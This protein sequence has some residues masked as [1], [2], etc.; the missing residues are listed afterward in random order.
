MSQ[1]SNIIKDRVSYSH[2]FIGIFQSGIG[3]DVDEIV[4]E[5]EVPVESRIMKSRQSVI[6]QR[7]DVSKLVRRHVNQI[8]N[9][10]KSALRRMPFEKAEGWNGTRLDQDLDDL[11]MPFA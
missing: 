5:F 2:L 7:I 4:S 3:S 8:F 10:I 9:N 11:K 6:V 1:I